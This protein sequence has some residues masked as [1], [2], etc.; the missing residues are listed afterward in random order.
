M[1]MRCIFTTEDTYSLFDLCAAFGAL[2][3]ELDLPGPQ[4]ALILEEAGRVICDL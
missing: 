4:E 3:E 1:V 2:I